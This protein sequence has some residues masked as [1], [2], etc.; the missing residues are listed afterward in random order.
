MTAGFYANEMLHGAVITLELTA[1]AF[2]V[3][4]TAAAVLALVRVHGP[5]VLRAVVLGYVELVRGLPAILQLFVIY[6][7]LA[8]FG[9]DLSAFTAAFVWMCFYGT[10]YAIE[11]FRAGIEAVPAGQTEAGTALGL[12]SI[13]LN[14]RIVVPQAVAVMLPPLVNFLILELKSTTIVYIVGLHDIMFQ[15]RLG[16]AN[17]GQPLTIYLIAAG[18]YIVMNVALGRVGALFER[19]MGWAR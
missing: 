4:L 14:T 11:I 15:A 3:S 8:Q 7:G 17:S 1:G 16:A 6:F 5:K 9:F 12:G 2:A 19:R 10:G 13:A 18:F